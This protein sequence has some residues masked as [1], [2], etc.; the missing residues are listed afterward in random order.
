MKEQRNVRSV[1]GAPKGRHVKFLLVGRNE[2]FKGNRARRIYNGDRTSIAGRSARLLGAL[3]RLQSEAIDIVLL[4]YTFGAAELALFVAG[5][6]RDGFTGLIL[7]LDATQPFGSASSGASLPAGFT[8]K[9]SL[10][11]SLNPMRNSLVM[12]R[13][14][15]GWNGSISFSAKQR[16][17]LRRVSEGWTNQQVALHLSCTEGAVKATLQQLFRKMGV[18]KR[19]QIV[20]MAFEKELIDAEGSARGQPYRAREVATPLVSPDDL[21]GKEPICVGHFI[22]D[23]AR[24]RVWVRGVETHLTPKGFGLLAV[25]VMHPW[26]LVG[27]DTLCEIFWRNPTSQPDAL[28]V[29]EA[30]LRAKIEVSKTPRYVV[31]E[32][33]FGY[34]FNPLPSRSGAG[35]NDTPSIRSGESHPRPLP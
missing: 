35:E 5:A 31:T 2:E 33:S 7:Y 4:G 20:R 9:G 24:H 18:R 16:T 32:R 29:L 26:E 23:I 17:V 25:F 12:R 22:V 34:R 27:S 3:K 14:D 1:P 21:Q 13:Q 11:D 28:R 15:E 30:A 6:R 19:A 10:E 8:S